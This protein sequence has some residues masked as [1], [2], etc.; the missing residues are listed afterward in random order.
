MAATP[1]GAAASEQLTKALINLAAVGQRT[2]CS[3]PTTHDLWL[4]E[5]ESERAV[6]AGLCR[7][8]P[9]ILECRE[10]G[11]YQSWG[12]FGGCD[13]TR[14]NKPGPRPKVAAS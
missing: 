5:S 2:H 10:V 12:V 4:S 1:R 8:C 9:V 13:F 6:A 7:R 11:K 3:D 14:R